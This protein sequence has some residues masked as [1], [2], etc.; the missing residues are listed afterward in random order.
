[1]FELTAA[2]PLR[3]KTHKSGGLSLAEMDLGQMT[4]L[5]PFKGKAALLSKAMETAHGVAIPDPNRMI[6]AHDVKAIWFGKDT[7]L[8]TGAQVDARLKAH[9]AITDQSDAW[10]CLCLEGVGGDQ[11]LARLVPVDLRLSHFAEGQTV[12]TQIGHMT[13]SVTRL[14][15]N[16]F[17]IM[18]F[19]S[20]AETLF[21]EVSQAM[22]AVSLRRIL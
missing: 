10:T 18:V 12:R 17:L 14:G 20:M 6:A 22:Q 8:L 9:A 4:L 1:M 13:G 19:R 11:V 16:Q 7:V 15:P 5:M 21:H 3:G 2:S